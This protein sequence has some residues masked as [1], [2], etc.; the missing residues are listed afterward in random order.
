M[1]GNPAS[2]L[3]PAMET[4]HE[5]VRDAW[6]WWMDWGSVML[7]QGKDVYRGRLATSAEKDAEGEAALEHRVRLGPPAARR[8][9]PD[10]D[11]TWAEPTRWNQ[12]F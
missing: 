2:W 10:P 11:G 3:K 6:S 1:V 7:G 9:G 5:L 4:L 8:F 12:S